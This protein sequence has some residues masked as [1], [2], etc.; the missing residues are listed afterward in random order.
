MCTPTLAHL[1]LFPLLFTNAL[2]AAAAAAAALLRPHSAKSYGTL[3][4]DIYH[5]A[6]SVRSG[7]DTAAS[8]A[9]LSVL[10]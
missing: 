8:L 3:V 10:F 9:P 5:G 4:G 7:S 2:A 6:G 1:T